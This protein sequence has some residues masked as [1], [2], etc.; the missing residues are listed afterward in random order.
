MTKSKT[1]KR[2]PHSKAPQKTAQEVMEEGRRVSVWKFGE[3]AK[4][5]I[6]DQCS[7]GSNLYDAADQEYVLHRKENKGAFY[8]QTL[9]AGVRHHAMPPVLFTEEVDLEVPR[10]L[11]AL[12]RHLGRT[13]TIETGINSYRYEKLCG[14]YHT[15]LMPYGDGRIIG[16]ANSISCL[17]MPPGLFV[18]LPPPEELGRLTYFMDTHLGLTLWGLPRTVLLVPE[19]FSVPELPVDNT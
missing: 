12:A 5:F 14:Q 3:V 8:W 17:G 9:A 10:T 6:I 15:V 18:L 7:R 16:S 1:R 4:A 2:N 11:A 19:G 13:T